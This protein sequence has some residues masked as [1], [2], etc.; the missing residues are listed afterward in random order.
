MDCKDWG[1]KKEKFGKG[2]G[3][4]EKVKEEERIDF[5]EVL[6]KRW[7]NSGKAELCKA[8]AEAAAAEA[9]ASGGKLRQVREPASEGEQT[10]TAGGNKMRGNSTMVEKRKESHQ[11]AENNIPRAKAQK[12]TPARRKGYFYLLLAAWW[13]T[14]KGRRWLARKG[15]KRRLEALKE[16]L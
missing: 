6:V 11:M 10:T 3:C 2:A 7:R 16:S 12:A 8:A 15:V 14:V 5:C 9:A 1:K 4:K 13:P